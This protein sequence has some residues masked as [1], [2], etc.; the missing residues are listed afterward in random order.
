MKALIIWTDDGCWYQHTLGGVMRSSW[1]G[2]VGSRVAVES[3]CASKGIGFQVWRSPSDSS[4][5][6]LAKPRPVRA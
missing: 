3:W 6:Q 2:H 5:R 1:L 4:S